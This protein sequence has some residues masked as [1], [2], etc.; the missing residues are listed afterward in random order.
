LNNSVLNFAK[1]NKILSLLKQIKILSKIKSDN[2]CLLGMAL[3]FPKLHKKAR[4][5]NVKKPSFF[6]ST[7]VNHAK[8]QV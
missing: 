7:K 1:L 4:C 8:M 2:K 6:V 5:V 3:L